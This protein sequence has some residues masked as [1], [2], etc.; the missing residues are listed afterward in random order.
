M[1]TVGEEGPTNVTW[2][3][4]LVCPNDGGR[5][6]A[7]GT[8]TPSSGR[9][10]GTLTCELCQ[11][12]FEV[13]D[14]IA[15]FLGQ[16]TE[17]LAGSPDKLHEAVARDVGASTYDERM[18]TYRNRLEIPPTLD[19]LDANA[20][21]IVAELGC[22]TGRMTVLFLEAV[23]HVVAVDFSVASLVRLRDRVSPKLREKLFLVHADVARP[24]LA[25]GAFSKVA[26]FQVLEHLPSAEER[27]NC[28]VEARQLLREGTG[29]LTLSVYNWS[30]WKQYDAKR[31]RG[32]NAKKEGHHSTTPPIYYYNF[33]EPELRKLLEDSDFAVQKMSGLI[34]QVPGLLALG[35]FGAPIHRALS[36]TR[37]GL[38]NGHL[39][40][41]HARAKV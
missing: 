20:D 13:E 16:D 37:F 41:A 9:W 14:G 38:R 24:P 17:A 36:K 23:R 3:D 31:G 21:D 35:R 8:E 10:S 2:T 22:G 18:P 1:S 28:I 4:L 26:S 39:L 6:H 29:T 15:R 27:Q 40:L 33:E 25:K 5:L 34:L 30:T 19:A 12:A 7:S 11:L 32:D